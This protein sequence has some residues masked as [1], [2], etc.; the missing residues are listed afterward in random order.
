MFNAE[1][2]R[3]GFGISDDVNALSVVLKQVQYFNFGKQKKWSIELFGKIR[4]QLIRQKQ[5]Y[6]HVS[7]LGYYENVLRG[8]ELYVID[9]M[10]FGMLKTSL[11]YEVLNKTVDFGTYMPLHAFK[12]L[13]F[14]V[15]FS[16]HNDCLLYT[17]PS[18]RDS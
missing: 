4:S 3:D 7:S 13:P 16:L 18:P 15:Y 17:S 5:P 2:Q 10:D 9:G 1:L 6:T 11:R 14:R 8:Y 12:V